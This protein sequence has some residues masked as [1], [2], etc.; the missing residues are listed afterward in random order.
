VKNGHFGFAC[1][2]RICRNSAK[3]PG[4]QQ[5]G[6][7]WALQSTHAADLYLIAAAN[8]TEPQGHLRLPF[9]FA[10]LRKISTQMI[11]INRP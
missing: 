4:L 5:T 11:K 8:Q 10:Y 3:Q 9:G 1:V 7:G 2:S 6:E